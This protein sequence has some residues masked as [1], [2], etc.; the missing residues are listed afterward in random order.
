MAAPDLA[1]IQALLQAQPDLRT[2]FLVDSAA[3]LELIEAWASAQPAPLPFEVMLEVGFAGGRT[4]CRSHEEAVALALRLHRS[5]AVRLVGIECYEGLW[6]K[7][8]T[9]VDKPYVDALMDRAE[10]VG[11]PLRCP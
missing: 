3:Q 7:G 8:E 5:T 4:G 11:S 6:A 1:G 2:V 10:A 9:A